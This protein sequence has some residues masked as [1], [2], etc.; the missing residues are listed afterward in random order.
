MNEELERIVLAMEADP[1][2]TPESIAAV[3]K[4]YEAE[5]DVDSEQQEPL[6]WGDQVRGAFAVSA[7]VPSFSMFDPVGNVLEAGYDYYNKSKEAA[8]KA[9]KEERD[10]A[11]Q[12]PEYAAQVA[13]FNSELDKAFGNDAKLFGK[14]ILEKNQVGDHEDHVRY[15]QDMVH[16]QL[17]F[18]G[19]IPSALGFDSRSDIAKDRYGLLDKDV[20]NDLIDQK[21]YKVTDAYEA[22]RRTEAAVDKAKT[23]DN[24]YEWQ[25]ETEENTRASYTGDNQ[26][27]ARSVQALTE[28]NL[29][30]DAWDCLLY[31]SPSPRDATLSRM[32]SSA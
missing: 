4:Q 16:N 25:A 22:T 15:V 14:T 13:D 24:V 27:I 6:T 10:E 8:E 5:S 31:T 28:G 30:G 9:K 2:E 29:E 26:L 21:V 7:S 18:S 17:D 20:V 32:P 1:N 3:I 23:V 19:D 11:M 12:D